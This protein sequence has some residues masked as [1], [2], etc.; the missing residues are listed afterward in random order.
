MYAELLSVI[1]TVHL[2]LSVAFGISRVSAAESDTLCRSRCFA[3]HSSLDRAA[4]PT[5][6]TVQL[7]IA[8][9][10][11]VSRLNRRV[12]HSELAGSTVRAAQ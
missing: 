4:E 3:A 10:L 8:E 7:L 11:T 12:W 1:D 9:L 5:W 6:P 2:P